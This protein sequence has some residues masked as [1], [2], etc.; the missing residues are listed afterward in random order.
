MVGMA[1]IAFVIAFL[2]VIYSY[3]TNYGIKQHDIRYMVPRIIVA[4]FLVNVSYYLCAILIDVSNILGTAI[5]EL[6][7]KI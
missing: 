2:A 1:N 6:L 5:Q 3:I 7:S 4:A